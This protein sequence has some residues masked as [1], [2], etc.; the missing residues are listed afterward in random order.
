MWL[1]IKNNIITY[2]DYRNICHHTDRHSFRCCGKRSIWIQQEGKH[3]EKALIPYKLL[4]LLNIIFLPIQYY[5][6][7][8]KIAVII[9]VPIDTIANKD[10]QEKITSREMLVI[11]P[12]DKNVIY[13]FFTNFPKHKRTDWIT[14][15]YTIKQHFYLLAAPRE[16]SL[17]SRN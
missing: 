6:Q 5:N 15:H 1:Q 3:F 11:K 12:L 14:T 10:L 7:F 13:S 17:Y 2:S 16:F 8:M 4:L 9:T